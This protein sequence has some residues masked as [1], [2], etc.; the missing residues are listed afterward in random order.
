MATCIELDCLAKEALDV[1][2]LRRFMRNFEI[3]GA[4]SDVYFLFGEWGEGLQ[5]PCKWQPKAV[6]N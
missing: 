5:E 4:F 2:C 1:F 6:K 3:S